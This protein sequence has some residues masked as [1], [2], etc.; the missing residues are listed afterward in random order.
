MNVQHNIPAS[1]AHNIQYSEKYYDDKFEYRHVIL[2]KE[3]VKKVPQ[4]RLLTEYD[5]RSLG[6]QMSRGW[7]HYGHHAPEP[8]ILLFRRQNP[9]A[10]QKTEPV[11][12]NK[13]GVQGKW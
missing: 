7:I 1:V 10:P 11:E 6:I 5:W 2:P 8:H 4:D 12:P 13:Q 9:N 3:I